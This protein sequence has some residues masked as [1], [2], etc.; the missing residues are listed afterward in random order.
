MGFFKVGIILKGAF[1]I[2]LS[3]RKDTCSSVYFGN[4]VGCISIVAIEF[5]FLLKFF[6]RLFHIC[7]RSGLMRLREQRAPDAV[8]NAELLWIDGKHGSVFRDG[9]VV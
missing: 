4:F 3:L 9:I 1:K 2:L 5:Q 6:S 8:V 7:L